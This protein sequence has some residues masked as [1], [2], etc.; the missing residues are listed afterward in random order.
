M[1]NRQFWIDTEEYG[2][3]WVD[4][5]EDAMRTIVEHSILYGNCTVKGMDKDLPLPDD[6]KLEIEKMRRS[7]GP[8]DV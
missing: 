1:K 3:L 6:W 8:T 7:M 5:M 4:D 2:K